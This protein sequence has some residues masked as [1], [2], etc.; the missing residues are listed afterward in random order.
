MNVVKCLIQSLIKE[1]AVTYAVMKEN[2]DITIIEMHTSEL[3]KHG[4]RILFFNRSS[5]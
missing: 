3:Y 2:V 4:Y 5:K 1:P